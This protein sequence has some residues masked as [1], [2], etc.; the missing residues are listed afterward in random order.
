MTPAPASTR[1]RAPV[2]I[3]VVRSLI[4]TTVGMRLSS[5]AMIATWVKGL[6]RSMSSA[7]AEGSAATQPGSV[8]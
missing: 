7:D 6:P 1:S 2:G 4:P 5:R 8:R 3:A